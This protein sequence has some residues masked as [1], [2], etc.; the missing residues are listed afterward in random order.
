MIMEYVSGGELFDHIVK[1]G[2]TTEEEAR[3][4]FQQI[5]CA[6]EYCHQHNVV[7]RDLK[8]EN[9]LL[10]THG[11]VKIAD[12]GLSNV[13]T[14]GDFLRTSCGSPNY[15][16]PEVVSGKYVL[17]FLPIH[18]C[19]LNACVLDCTPEQRSTCGRAVL[20]STHCSVGGCHSTTSTSPH[21]LSASRVASLRSRRSCR[22][23]HAT[24][25]SQC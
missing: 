25:C 3:R 6:V 12:F 20:S 10:D 21:C 4:F 24:S 13:M 19:L 5:I 1:N 2:R 11:N 7:H 8:P 22:P 17:F 15:A 23:P 16:A 14:D 9:V 18:W